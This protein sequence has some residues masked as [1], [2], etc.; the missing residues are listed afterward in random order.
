VITIFNRR[1]AKSLFNK[2]NEV[3]WKL[4]RANLAEFMQLLQR[5]VRLIYLN[6]IGG[7][8]RGFG[9]AIGL[10]IIAG[11]FLL[12]LTK[13]AG[14]NLPVIGKFIADLVRIVNF[15]LRIYS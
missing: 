13:L 9:I 7:L 10:T 15:H 3:E 2:L 8:A 5:P 14:M 11:L 4:E 6:F 1:L 12:F